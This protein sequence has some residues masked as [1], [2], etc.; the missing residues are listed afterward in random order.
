MIEMKIKD[1]SKYIK[2]VEE[3][4]GVK[5]KLHDIEAGCKHDKWLSDEV[6][7][8][9]QRTNDLINTLILWMK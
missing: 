6:Q 7:E 3:L 1:K 8:L 9:K 4:R 2:T 5:Q